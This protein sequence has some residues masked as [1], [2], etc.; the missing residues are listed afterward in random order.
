MRRAALLQYGVGG[1]M[2]EQ[3]ESRGASYREM[4]RLERAKLDA[5]YGGFSCALYVTLYG[6]DASHVYYRE[7]LSTIDAHEFYLWARRNHDVELPRI[8]EY[9]KWLEKNP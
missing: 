6:E 5:F 7:A 1:A 3:P 4:G 9:L 2:T 8:R